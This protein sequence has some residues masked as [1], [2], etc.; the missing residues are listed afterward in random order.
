MVH[1][2][3]SSLASRRDKA[4]DGAIIASVSYK[5]GTKDVCV[6]DHLTSVTKNSLS[7]IP[8]LM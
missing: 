6:S 7:V 2:I 4:D 3:M 8:I 5:T 1:K